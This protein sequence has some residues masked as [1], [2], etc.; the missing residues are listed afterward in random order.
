MQLLKPNT[1]LDWFRIYLLY[2]KAFPSY[3]RKPF[4]LIY[5]TNK[6]GHTDVWIL[7]NNN[8]FLGLAITMNDLDLVLLDYFA[9]EPKY[10]NQGLGTK[11]LHL[12][13]H[14]YQNQRLFI[15]IESTFV[16]CDNLEER[17]KRKDF[18][19]RNGMKELNLHA[20]VF[21]T[22]MELLSFQTNI[23]FQDYYNTYL[24]IYG[25]FSADH[26]K[27]LKKDPTSSI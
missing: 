14:H 2:K 11:A 9:I 23:T 12:L 19:L 22:E 18:Y 6:K 26:L 21:G 1:C 4:S 13:H 17:I 7:S 20:N 27:E 10:R 16:D 8:A 5:N 25:K 3:E 24:H 15:E